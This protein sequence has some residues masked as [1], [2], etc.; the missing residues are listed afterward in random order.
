MLQAFDGAL[1]GLAVND[2]IELEVS[3]QQQ[4]Q[5]QQQHHHH[6]HHHHHP[7]PPPPPPAAHPAGDLG[8]GRQGRVNLAKLLASPATASSSCFPTTQ[9]FAGCCLQHIAGL[10][11]LF[12]SKAELTVC[13]TAVS[14]Y[15]CH[16]APHT[17]LRAVC[18]VRVCCAR[19]V[20]WYLHACKDTCMHADVRLPSGLPACLQISGGEWKK[21]LLFSVPRDHPEI[22]RLEGRYKK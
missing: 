12:S 11:L 18:W 13:D 8:T 22:A 15:G 20:R 14:A 19:H 16:S 6:H 5:Q 21:E 2:F 10:S 3:Q 7:P 9:C 17:H 1:R 4:Q